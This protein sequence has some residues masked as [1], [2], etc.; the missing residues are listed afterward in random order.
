M[1]RHRKAGDQMRLPREDIRLY[2]LFWLA[3]M[4]LIISGLYAFARDGM[5]LGIAQITLG[6][7]VG[8]GG[9]SLVDLRTP[10]D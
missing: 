2:V 8:P 3:S 10:R 6:F 5:A 4:V 9:L 1:S 7:V